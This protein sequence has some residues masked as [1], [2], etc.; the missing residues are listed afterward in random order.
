MGIWPHTADGSDIN[1][2]DR[3][4]QTDAVCSIRVPQQQVHIPCQE[5][6]DRRST[7]PQA[8]PCIAQLYELEVAA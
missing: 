4:V 1:A 6:V 3:W 7:L 8:K 5:C 2:C